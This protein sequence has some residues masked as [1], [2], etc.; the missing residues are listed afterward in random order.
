MDDRSLFWL[1]C[2]D[3]LVLL[4]RKLNMI[5]LSKLSILGVPDEGY[6]RNASSALKKILFL[7]SMIA[8]SSVIS[9]LELFIFDEIM[10]AFYYNKALS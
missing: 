8:A 2:L 5:W 3:P 7:C 9:G 4:L 10:S 1:S 6:S